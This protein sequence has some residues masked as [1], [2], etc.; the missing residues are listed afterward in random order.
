MLVA[1]SSESLWIDE[2]VTA[3]FASLRTLQ[4]L[5]EMLLVPSGSQTPLHFA[6]YFLW[7]KLGGS[8]ELFLRF[9]NLPLFVLGQLAIFWALRTYP[10]KLNFLVLALGALHPLVWMYANEARQ[11]IMMYAGAQM[12]LAY[13]INLH[14]GG[15]AG[16]TSPLALLIFVLGGI[17][18][19]GSSLLGAFWVFAALLYIAHFHFKHLDSSYLRHGLSLFLVFIFAAV[20][21]ALLI[22]YVNSLAQGAGAS[23]LSSTTPATVVFAVY[24]LLGLSGVG[25]SRLQLRATGAA[26]L[27][28][29]GIW[30][31]PMVVVVL[32]TLAAGLIEAKKRLGAT[33]L[34]VLCVL[35]LFPVAVVVTSGFVMHWRVLGRHLIA[36]L[37]VLNLLFATGLGSLLVEDTRPT[38][39]VRA[40]VAISCLVLLT[41]SSLSLRFSE[42][43]RKDDYRAAVAIAQEAVKKGQRVWWAAAN[44]GANH[45]GLVGEFDFMGEI[46]GVSKPIECTDRPSVQPVAHASGECLKKLS[47]PDVVIFS[48]PDVFDAS[49]VIAQDLIAGRYVEAQY[50][51]AFVV[52]RSAL[53]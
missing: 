51:P 47:V 15:T 7:G 41:I 37:P 20:I 16:R 39:A 32:T 34:A 8:S 2:F 48:K 18:L 52:W 9:A 19:F 46:T 11:Y 21:A 29:Y 13:L 50:L 27:A 12:I 40:A 53:K 45:Y 23:R 25:P 14:G 1:I 35:A 24:E 49:G 5:R 28:Q 36:M 43:H 44:L 10:R 3:Y 17:M 33:R 31:V 6:Y 4:E 30:L 22:Y 26:T 38:W 42:R